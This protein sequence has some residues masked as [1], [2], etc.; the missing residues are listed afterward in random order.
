M[1]TIAFIFAVSFLAIA[2]EHNDTGDKN[3][4]NTDEAAAY[5][6]QGD[7][8]AKIT[9]DTL[10]T[11][12]L[13]VIGQKGFSGALTFCNARAM[14]VTAIYANEGITVSRV[15]DKNRNPKNA[16][17]EYDM[18]EWVKYTGEAAKKDSLKSTVVLRDHEF[19][20]YKPI[21]IQSM[22]LSC[23]GIPG[24]D[25]PKDLVQVI[26]SLYPGDKA[27]GYKQGDLRGMWHIVFRDTKAGPK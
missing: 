13:K 5:V 16:L 26:D 15:S 7:R 14:A 19:H 4:K 22:C 27:K 21:L 10:R 18:K 23:H 20:Y 8:I 9:F 1:K 24:K 12:L 25:I 17:S 2:C 3:T 6:L 11:T